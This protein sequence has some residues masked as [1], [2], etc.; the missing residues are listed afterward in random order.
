MVFALEGEVPARTCLNP[1]N[2]ETEETTF[3]DLILKHP[4]IVPIR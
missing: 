2:L 1:E 3:T 4:T